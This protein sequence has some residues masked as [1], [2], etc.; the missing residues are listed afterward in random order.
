[1]TNSVLSDRLFSLI[2]CHA[3]WAVHLCHCPF[4]W[5]SHFTELCSGRAS[6]SDLG[7]P[8]H[9]DP[10][11]YEQAPG[12]RAS[13]APVFWA[14]PTAQVG[15]LPYMLEFGKGKRVK[16]SLPATWNRLLQLGARGSEKQAA[17]A[18]QNETNPEQ[19]VGRR[20]LPCWP[21]LPGVEHL[22]WAVTRRWL[23]E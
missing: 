12:L 19:G 14:P 23:S 15:Q 18:S 11:P 5:G 8:S 1:M 13:R 3:S 6:V 17:S 16:V 22:G 2:A 21:H 9:V 7:C 10:P 4:S 20:A